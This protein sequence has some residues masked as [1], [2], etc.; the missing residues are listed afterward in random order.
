M[1]MW[2]EREGREVRGGAGLAAISAWI[3]LVQS[4]L[5]SDKKAAIHSAHVLNISLPCLLHAWLEGLVFSTDARFNQRV[6][7]HKV[8]NALSQSQDSPGCAGF[9]M[10]C[11]LAC[12]KVQNQRVVC[13]RAMSHSAA[14]DL[15]AAILGLSVPYP[16]TLRLF[17][18]NSK[19]ILYYALLWFVQGSHA[20]SSSSLCCMICI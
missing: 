19:S 16:A 8:I 6:P 1:R 4:H 14:L 17:D 12:G 3:A 11:V 5:I 2:V 20:V 15:A 7:V 9:A 13:N 10:R 18:C